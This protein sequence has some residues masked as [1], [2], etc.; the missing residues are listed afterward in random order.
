MREHYRNLSQG[1]PFGK[2]RR[3]QWRKEDGGT[4]PTALGKIYRERG[5]GSRLAGDLDVS[6]VCFDNGHNQ[7]EPL[8]KM[9]RANGFQGCPV[10]GGQLRLLKNTIWYMYGCL[11]LADHIIIYS[12]MSWCL[13]MERTQSQ[14]VDILHNPVQFM[15]VAQI[16]IDFCS[17]LC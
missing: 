16:Q 3:S 6:S 17:W 8:P 9:V 5:T 10:S 1:L 2:V 4:S 12:E 7:T 13:A 14:S 11:H 15:V